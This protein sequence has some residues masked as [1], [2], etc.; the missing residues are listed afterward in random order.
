MTRWKASLIHLLISILVVGI[1]AAYIIFFWYPPALMHMAKADRL[2]MLIGGV[3]LVVGPLLTLIIYKAGKKYLKLDLVI[4]GLIQLVFLGYGIYATWNSRPVFLVAVPDRFELVFANEITEKRL[5]Q[6]KVE[7]FKKLSVTRPV[8]V[9]ASMPNAYKEKEAILMSAASGEGDIQVMP[10][11]FVEYAEVTGTLIKN[12][13]PLTPSKGLDAENAKILQ[14][15][16]MAYGYSASDLRYLTLASSRGFAVMLVKADSGEIV[17][18]VNA[19][20]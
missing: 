5:S 19:D 8:L 13:K 17:G 1:I 15:A 3:D 12:A 2:L 14:Q 10:E 16:A 7:R 11:Y 20:P 18:P 9:G 6:A 4:I